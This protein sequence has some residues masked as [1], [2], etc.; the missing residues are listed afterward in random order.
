MLN[1]SSQHI[2][3]TL[4]RIFN[5]APKIPAG[6]YKAIRRFSPHFKCDLLML[7]DVPGHDFIEIHPANWQTQLNG[8]IAVGDEIVQNTPE[9]R[10]LG[11]SRDAFGKFM[12]SM[13]GVDEISLTIHNLS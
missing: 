12:E 6:T 5:G 1:A 2:C 9:T 13:N 8:C 3:F 4:E 11:D 7:V 10:M